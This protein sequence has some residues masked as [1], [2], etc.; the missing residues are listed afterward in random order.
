MAA[1]TRGSGSA[2]EDPIGG[3]PERAVSFALP[4]DL[5][6]AV[7]TLDDD[8]LDRLVKAA[9]A[10]SRRR[11]RDAPRPRR[12]R[13]QPAA[14]TPGQERMILAAF[15]AGLKPAAIAREFRL[16]RDRVNTVV[17]AKRRA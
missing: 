5:G 2:G 7:R 13:R 4:A 14:V 15:D 3:G 17:A 10:E 11:G 12:S 8:S 16:S 9:V 6:R 1:R